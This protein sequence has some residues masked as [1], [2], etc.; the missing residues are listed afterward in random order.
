[1]MNGKLFKSSDYNAKRYFNK[2][3]REEK[4]K[5]VAYGL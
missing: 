4:I 2:D 3:K 1:M 5:G